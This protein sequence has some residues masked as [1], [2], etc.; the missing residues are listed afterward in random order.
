MDSLWK[1]TPLPQFPQLHGDLHTE[2]L[3]IGGGMAGLLTAYLLQQAG[4]PCLLVER[5][6]IGSGTTGGTTAKITVQHGFIYQKLL[7]SL[8]VSGAKA[9]LEANQLAFSQYAQLCA[10]LDC[11]YEI[12]DNYVYSASPEA[13]ERELAALAQIGARAERRSQLPLPA[14][15]AGA[16][17]FPNQAQFHPRKF[18]A[19]IV[20][21]LNIFENTWV[22]ALS[23][24]T[25]VT[26]QGIIHAKQVVCATHFPF[27]N[28]HGLFFFKLY[29]HRSYVLAL[30]NAPDIGGMYVDA[31][32]AGF[33]F[34]NAQ[35]LLLLGG[36][37]AH[38]GKSRGGWEPLRRFAAE[39][40]PAAR[41][42]YAWAAQ[43]CMSLDGMP[44]IGPYSAHTP[45]VYV[46]TGFHKWGMTGSMLSAL[47][48]RDQILGIANPFAAL[49]DPSRSIWKLQLLYNGAAAVGN[50]LRPAT[51]RCPHM[52][53][54][55]KWNPYEHSWD[56]P[57]HGSRFAQE[58]TLLDNPANTDM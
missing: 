56:C 20:G 42:V 47:L 49:F 35:G 45:G 29:Q 18:L 52:G 51:P 7:K 30:E 39:H 1:K 58:G 46:E 28:N 9:Y 14:A 24:T 53:C 36:G 16:V 31:D 10:G 25:A 26:D 23:G 57:C 54:A 43:D 11:D 15:A 5:G 33:S 17:C 55:L 12:K 32:H 38:T 2:V 3:I 6:R 48:I 27:L 21:N 13:V 44:Y 22:S 37:G 50:L 4:V 8:G 34:R 19:G 40:Y 41:E